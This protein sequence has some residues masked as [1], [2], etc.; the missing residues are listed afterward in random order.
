[1]DSSDR[2]VE[3]S[4][5]RQGG[6]FASR[7]IPLSR[8]SSFG[9][10]FR[11]KIKPY[12]HLPPR[13]DSAGL[14]PGD[15]TDLGGVDLGKPLGDLGL[16]LGLSTFVHGMVKAFN[17]GAGEGRSGLKRELHGFLKKPRC[18]W[19]HESI[20]FSRRAV[21]KG[22]RDRRWAGPSRTRTS[23]GRRGTKTGRLTIPR[24]AN[25]APGAALAAARGTPARPVTAS[26]V[27]EA[28]GCSGASAASGAARP[29]VRRRANVALLVGS[30]DGAPG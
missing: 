20:V 21:G 24:L 29:R 15:R 19:F 16:P 17:E 13:D 28:P 10:R 2:K 23:S 27:T 26:A 5:K 25:P 4:Q 18:I 14:R 1:L 30:F 7:G 22:P 11:V 6:E 9:D 3:F 12:G 8:S